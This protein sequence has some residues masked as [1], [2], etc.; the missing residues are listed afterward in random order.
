MRLAELRSAIT[1]TPGQK[2]GYVTDVADTPANRGA[3][4]RLVQNANLLFIEFPFA[5]ADAALAAERAHLT[6]YAAKL[7]QNSIP[8][9]LEDE[10]LDAAADQFGRRAAWTDRRARTPRSG[11]R[12]RPRRHHL[13]PFAAVEPVEH[14]HQRRAETGGLFQA[15][16][17]GEQSEFGAEEFADHFI[18]GVSCRSWRGRASRRGPV[19]LFR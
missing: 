13:R 3:I 2:I 1:V 5:E 19:G 12:G 11:D 17:A 7:D 10:E 15:Q 4:I 9:A 6:T 16:N 8:G 18:G 14:F